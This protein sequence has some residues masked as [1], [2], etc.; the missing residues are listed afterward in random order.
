MDTQQYIIITMSDILGNGSQ[1]VSKQKTHFFF[2]FETS[3]KA[4][5]KSFTNAHIAFRARR[6]Q[7]VSDALVNKYL[8]RKTVCA[9]VYISSLCSINF[10]WIKQRELQQYLPQP[11]AIELHGFRWFN[12][13]QLYF[14]N[15]TRDLT[16]VASICLQSVVKST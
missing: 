9:T 12:L 3:T 10:Y 4:I 15:N 2:L 7:T 5:R 11:F 14:M 8:T 13:F 1:A 16:K 6:P